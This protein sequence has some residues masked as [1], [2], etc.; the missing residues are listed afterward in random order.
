MVFQ[1]NLHQIIVAHLPQIIATAITII[2]TLVVRS[3]LFK[4]LRKYMV[5]NHVRS[6]IE[7]V[8]RGISI[9]L[10]SLAF[11]VIITIW[12]VDKQNILVT[13]SSVFAIIGVALFAQWS[14]LSNVTAG[15]II[16]FNSP[17]SIG[18]K[19]RI[20]DK[21]F[22]MEAV[23]VNI[24]TFYTHLRTDDGALHVYPNTLLL[25]K[26][27]SIVEDEYGVDRSDSN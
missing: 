11:L 12:G 14:V 25:Q 1:E 9:V 8:L 10:K 18:D 21:D 3:V 15:L 19:I 2:V 17:L 6:R 20:L 22:P 4:L 13:L 27:I 24:K 26:G 16:F 7:P 23:I 5:G